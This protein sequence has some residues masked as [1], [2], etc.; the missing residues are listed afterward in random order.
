MSDIN[1]ILDMPGITLK[2]QTHQIEVLGVC[3]MEKCDKKSRL[4]CFKCVCDSH[5]HNKF[6]IPIEDLLN[7]DGEDCKIIKCKL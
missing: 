7:E 6:I 3:M 4:V 2:C 1:Y 5:K